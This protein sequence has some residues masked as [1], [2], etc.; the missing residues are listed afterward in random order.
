MHEFFRSD[1]VRAIVLDR[2]L[3]DLV[4]FLMKVTNIAMRAGLHY[5]FDQLCHTRTALVRVINL[6]KYTV[7][8][9]ISIK[10][11]CKSTTPSFIPALPC[12]PPMSKVE[13]IESVPSVS[14]L[15]C[16]MYRYKV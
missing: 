5:Q 16:L 15:S 11:G 14:S 13:E 7:T 2:K 6:K 1:E 9:P 10:L 4:W 8:N 3:L 12:L